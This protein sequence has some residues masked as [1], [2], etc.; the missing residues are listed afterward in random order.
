[1]TAMT[2]SRIPR[3]IRMNNPGN[4][5]ELPGDKTRW[6]GERATDDDP[7]FEEFGRPEDGIRALAKVL[8]TYQRKHGL[9]TVRAL[10]ARWAP[11]AENDTDSYVGAVAARMGIG[12]DGP[13]MLTDRA[14]LVLLVEAIIRHENGIQPYGS[15]VIEAGIDAALEA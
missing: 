12:P 9:S 3:G 5:K 14:M 7:V 11:P 2:A 15:D 10:I 8:L 1:M 6:K 4:I 13:V